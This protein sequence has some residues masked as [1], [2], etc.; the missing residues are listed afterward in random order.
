MNFDLIFRQSLG[1]SSAMSN[2]EKKV[3][4]KGIGDRERKREGE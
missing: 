3:R 1:D 2:K 4:K